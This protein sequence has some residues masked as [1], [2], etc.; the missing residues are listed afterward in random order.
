MARLGAPHGFEIQPDI[1]RKP[2]GVNPTRL[3]DNF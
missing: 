1:F 2:I 3:S